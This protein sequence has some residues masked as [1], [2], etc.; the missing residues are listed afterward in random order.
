M[1]ACTSSHNAKS[2]MA[3]E[4]TIISVPK[5]KKT[6]KCDKESMQLTQCTIHDI[7]NGY[8][9]KLKSEN[10]ILFDIIPFEIVK[11]CVLYYGDHY[12]KKIYFECP[13]LKT[14]SVQIAEFDMNSAVIS[15]L[16]HRPLFM[17]DVINNIIAMAYIPDAFPDKQLDAI[18]C[19]KLDCPQPV[20]VVFNPA[21]TERD[22]KCVIQ[23][24][25]TDIKTMRFI[26]GG[27]RRIFCFQFARLYQMTLSTELKEITENDKFEICDKYQ[28]W[29]T[30]E[31]PDLCYLSNRQ[32]IFAM[33]NGSHGTWVCGIFDIKTRDWNRVHFD[34]YLSSYCKLHKLCYDGQAMIYIVGSIGTVIGYNLYTKT[35][36]R[37]ADR[38]YWSASKS[39]TV[40]VETFDKDHIYFMQTGLEIDLRYFNVKH[41]KWKRRNGYNQIE[42][43]LGKRAIV[44]H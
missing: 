37:Y 12:A 16:K 24:L 33:N 14:Q 36:T 13:A 20:L 35:W 4:S 32:Q 42:K 23:R 10:I 29:N 44:L 18:L 22:K 7:I 30:Y 38:R 39:F 1:G 41:R 9:R 31:K 34:T 43:D 25:N 19:K 40:W 15:Y 27:E 21:N 11:V 6:R 17:D 8:F 28:F 3:N 2:S 26:Y 5:A